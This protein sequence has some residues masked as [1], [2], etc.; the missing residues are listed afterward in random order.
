MAAFLDILFPGSIFL[1]PKAQGSCRLLGIRNR[2]LPP[3]ISLHRFWELWPIQKTS[4]SLT[5]E[6]VMIEKASLPWNA[7]PG[8]VPLD[9]CP[10]CINDSTITK[11]SSRFLSGIRPEWGLLSK[12]F[13]WNQPCYL[14]SQLDQKEHASQGSRSRPEQPSWSKVSAF[15]GQLLNTSKGTQLPHSSLPSLC[16]FPETSE[17]QEDCP[18]ILWCLKYLLNLTISLH[19]HCILF[20]FP[21]HPVPAI[22]IPIW[23][24]TIA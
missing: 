7:G 18:G 8:L 24:I 12:E 13:Y 1:C 11:F 23:T 10:N 3:R 9:S 6:V 20:S 22:I 5:E 17:S 2:I 19:S 4:A 16:S 14:I 21:L 15:Q